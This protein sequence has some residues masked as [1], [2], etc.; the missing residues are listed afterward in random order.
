MFQDI[1]KKLDFGKLKLPSEIE[2][3]LQNSSGDVLS[4]I[5]IWVRNF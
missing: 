1:L 3:V 4:N 2:N 5:A